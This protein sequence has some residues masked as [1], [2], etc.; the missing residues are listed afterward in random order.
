M[1]KPG[2]PSNEEARIETLHALNIL[3]THPDERFDRLARMAKRLFDVPISLVSLV[4]TNRQWFKSKVGL[5]AS[6]T[7]RDISFCGHAI[8]GDDIFIIPDTLE[9][10]RFANNPLVTNAPNIRFYAGCPLKTPDAM[11]VGTLCIIDKVPRHFNNDDLLALK[12][13]ATMVER[14][15]AALL[16]AT[17]DELTNISNR[18]GF[19][20]QT[21][22]LLKLSKRNKKP[23]SL[24]FMDLNDFKTLNDSFGHEAGDQSLVAFADLMKRT[25]RRSDIYARLG[26]DEFI[27]YL[28]D[29]TTQA[30]KEFVTRFTRA[31]DSYNDAHKQGYKLAF[32]H[33]IVG[34]DPKTHATIED[35]ISEGDKL[36]YLNKKATK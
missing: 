20:T 35:L 25:F 15:L 3:D 34:F 28:P 19:I 6:E 10:K 27:V 13:L 36:M 21:K 5:E 7:P 22:Q 12:D 31:L 11:K 9:D 16:M 33:G 29:T 4:D 2:T 17:V 8:L 18:R 30:A 26:G 24:I 1:Q 14:E 32:S 23:A